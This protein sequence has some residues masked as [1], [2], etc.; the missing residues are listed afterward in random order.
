MVRQAVWAAVFLAAASPAAAQTSPR[1]LVEMTDFSGLAVSPDG[2]WLLYRRERPS[3]MSGQIETAW[4]LV[5]TD[6]ATPPRRIG[7]GGHASW[8][9]TGIVEAGSAA[10]SPESDRFYFRARVDGATGLWEGRPSGALAPLIVRDA[11]IERFA[12]APDGGIIFELGPS[13]A[14]IARAEENE[15]DSGILADGRVDLAQ[16]LYRGA[17]I[18][19]RPASQRLNGDWFDR[20]ALLDR[21]P[22]QIV[23][24]DPTTAR[25]RPAH[26]IEAELLRPSP[27]PLPEPFRA[28]A[29]QA[30]IC[31]VEAPCGD[32]DAPK[33]WK[34]MAVGDGR[35]VVTTRDRKVRQSVFLWAKATGLTRLAASPGLL[36]GGGEMA[37]CAA[38]QTAAF[39]V[40]ESAAMP[41]QLQR[42]ALDG[43][44]TLV[45]D[46]PNDLPDHDDLLT[47]AIEWQV[48]GSRASGWLVRPKFPG[49]LPLFI[50]YYRCAGYLR[51]GLGNEWPLRALAA[52]GIAALC[53]N[54]LPSGGA[55]AEAR[56]ELGLAAVRAAVAELDRRGL[57]DPGRVGMGGLSFGSEVAMWTAT[58][59]KLLSAVS[60][61]SVQAEP[62]YYWFN[63][64]IGRD[65]FRQNLETQWGL[66]APDIDA[67][68]WK[69]RSPSLQVDK[70]TA[71]VL[72]QLPEQEARLSPE[73]QAR[74]SASGKG[75]LHVFPFA[76]HI[77][78]EPRQKLAVYQ[79]NLDWFRFWLQGYIDPDPAKIAQYARWTGLNFPA[80]KSET[81]AIQSSISASSSKRK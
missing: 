34:G 63:A 46:R 41:P 43:S 56:Y 60:I 12:V 31:A 66:G 4:Y 15:R 10:W 49:R 78:A 47:E 40:A 23:R 51:G 79:R 8:N 67:A 42:I 20:E 54:Q 6:G 30:G 57:V 58:H 44:G 9:G 53:I 17:M 19:G 59:S 76:P 72:M 48:G 52:S 22:R 11:D 7:D 25:E 29:S 24:R 1:E 36:S 65:F 21:L 55:K 37:A 2:R 13:R 27:Q 39:C 18:A 74:L 64:G 80:P 81:D 62:A 26:A 70:I 3:T 50:T 61:A 28:A 45:L 75:E 5:G 14:A 35:F 33:I 77:K 32:P 16:T 71:P 73:L 69:R 68:D 38:S